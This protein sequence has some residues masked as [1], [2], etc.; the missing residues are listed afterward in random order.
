MPQLSNNDRSIKLGHMSNIP[1]K[2]SSTGPTFCQMFL[3]QT[4]EERSANFIFQYRFVINS[5][6]RNAAFATSLFSYFYCPK[7]P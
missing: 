5:G 3:Q 7:K 2:C 1:I 6:V 4:K